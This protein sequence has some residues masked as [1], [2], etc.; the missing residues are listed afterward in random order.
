MKNLEYWQKIDPNFWQKETNNRRP[1][2]VTYNLQEKFLTNYFNQILKNSKKEM[3]ILDF[4]CGYGRFYKIIKNQ[5]FKSKYFGVDLSKKMIDYFYNNETISKNRLSLI[6]KDFKIPFP[7]NFFDYS[8]TVSVMIHNN[9][10]DAQK[11][12]NELSRVTKKQIIH[13]ENRFYPNEI[14]NNNAHEGCWYHNYKQLY[15]SPKNNQIFYSRILYPH[16]IYIVD[17]L[18]KEPSNEIKNLFL[19]ENN[20]D[21]LP[22][23][24]NEIFDFIRDY[25]DP[26]LEKLLIPRLRTLINEEELFHTKAIGSF[27]KK[28]LKIEQELK[29]LK[30]SKYFILFNFY[31]KLK[32]ILKKTEITKN[33]NKK[34]FIFEHIEG[35]FKTN[36]V[37]GI[38]HR[39]WHGIKRATINQCSDVILVKK[40]KT[41]SDAKLIAHQINTL[42][43][44]KIA[45]NGLPDGI[46]LLVDYLIKHFPNLQI[47]FVWHGS[48]TQ[49]SQ[50]ID[51]IFKLNLFSKYFK[52]IKKIGFVKKNME[53]VFKEFN[54][55]AEYL[56]NRFSPQTHHNHIKPPTISEN[57]F[58]IYIPPPFELRKNNVNQVIAASLIKNSSV[59]VTNFP[60]L[61]YLGK[62]FMNKIIIHGFLGEF[63]YFQLLQNI[64]LVMYIS[65]SECYPMVLLESLFYGKPCLVHKSLKFIFNDEKELQNYLLIE[66]YENIL[67]I[68]N[69]I[70]NIQDNYDA[71]SKLCLEYSLKLNA[72]NEKK[73]IEFFKG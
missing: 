19:I 35:T 11:I 27:E 37:I 4:G 69:K 73:I 34:R 58:N 5:K 55:V 20:L 17:L 16:G 26:V 12:A 62:W 25:K 57:K 2:D 66:D 60:H 47:F 49:Q 21:N 59:H 41:I 31:N 22:E 52:N 61:T 64:D 28:T 14:Y 42:N 46:E 32:R 45:I 8:F 65:I 72:E 29:Q 7:D 9:E 1:S 70:K 33:E 13:I 67:E 53:E 71:V 18:K 39:D 15:F 56:P 40:I 48:F 6:S 50:N 10:V 38:C 24:K 36:R 3:K 44:S 51:N 23:V 63:N 68:R 30:D 54:I 43:I